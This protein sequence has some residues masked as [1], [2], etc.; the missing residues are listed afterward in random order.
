MNPKLH[1]FIG[2]GGVV[3]ALSPL[4]VNSV[5]ADATSERLDA[6]K[7]NGL[8][9][10]EIKLPTPE[11][12]GSDSQEVVV[13][14]SNAL[15]WSAESA[16]V[17]KYADFSAFTKEDWEVVGK[18]F[19][20]GSEHDAEWFARALEY[21]GKIQAGEITNPNLSA[22]DVL[23][24]N[25]GNGV[26]ISGI[27]GKGASDVTL[28]APFPKISMEGLYGTNITFEG[29]VPDWDWS[30]VELYGVTF[31]DTVNMSQL[32][33]VLNKAGYICDLK[34]NGIN[35]DAE[36]NIPTSETMGYVGNVN[37]LKFSEA[38]AKDFQLEVLKSGGY[39]TYGADFS[40]DDLS[41]VSMTGTVTKANESILVKA[42]KDDGYIK[43]ENIV[44][45]N[46]NTVLDSNYKTYTNIGTV[47]CTQ[48]SGLNKDNIPAAMNY[49]ATEAQFAKLSSDI[50]ANYDCVDYRMKT[51]TITVKTAAG[52]VVYKL[53][54][55]PDE[56]GN[57]C[58][59]TTM[60]S[61]SLQWEKQ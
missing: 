10:Q 59:Y 13:F 51:P 28:R 37:G 61:V 55:T 56:N 57:H 18:F 36:P 22:E 58:N 3:I 7:A 20:N 50:M 27:G 15:S 2:G 54:E 17:A 6:Y 24:L 34:V 1:K 38:T 8:I 33:T 26:E 41:D 9:P 31:A 30:K 21:L 49:I 47:D 40:N 29:G 5:V 11:T 44:M 39:C 32:N 14:T 52:N 46:A 43:I 12:A 23:N 53:I 16:G 4:F 35:M 45:K 60:Q 48:V 42:P 25:G 19:A